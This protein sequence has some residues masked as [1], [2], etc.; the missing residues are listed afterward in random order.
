M[1]DSIGAA[2]QAAGLDEINNTAVTAYYL[3]LLRPLANKLGVA[4]LLIDHETKNGSGSAYSVGA[5]AKLRSVDVQW[6]LTTVSD[7]NRRRSG[8]IRLTCT[9]DRRGVIGKGTKRDAIVH[10]TDG[11][12]SLEYVPVDPGSADAAP[13]G[14]K[15]AEAKILE[16]VTAVNARG[17]TGATMAKIVDDIS[18]RHGHGLKRETVSRAL[19]VLVERGLVRKL[20]GLP[21]AAGHWQP[22][23]V[24]HGDAR[25]L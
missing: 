9:K 5:G 19:G 2:L 14:L 4:V 22:M 7:F 18:D 17:T 21:G 6:K 23:P 10:V 11:D 13:E 16:A 3:R 25:S 24:S 20:A 8:R 15:P 12:I 1:L